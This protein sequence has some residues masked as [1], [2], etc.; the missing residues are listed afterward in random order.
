MRRFVTFAFLSVMVWSATERMNMAHAGDAHRGEHPGDVKV[1]LHDDVAQRVLTVRIGPIDLPAH[2]HHMLLPDNF[3]TIPFDAWFTAYRPRV[4]DERERPLPGK[5]LHHVQ[6]YD[7]TRRDLICDKSEAFIFS[8]GSEVEIFLAPSGGG[9]RVGKGSRIRIRTMLHNPSET[10]FRRVYVEVRAN[11]RLVTDRPALRNVYVAWF[12][13]GNCPI[14]PEWT[15][16]M[17][18]L[19]PGKSVVTQQWTIDY[20]GKLLGLG[21]HLHDFGREVRLENVPRNEVIATLKPIL[22][23]KGILLKLP[24]V[25]LE[26]SGGYQLNRGDIVK[27]TGTYD[28]SSGKRLPMAGMVMATGAFLPDNDE[29]L[30]AAKR[31]R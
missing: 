21:G 30:V 6:F 9:Y 18:D 23:P 17:F 1:E 10:S 19:K 16:L 5:L 25:S 13:V 15:S 24:V 31:I 22:F 27:V 26:T 3:M 4:L 14:E 11:Y 8:A 20:P 29:E 7:T 28:N 12:Y 2:A